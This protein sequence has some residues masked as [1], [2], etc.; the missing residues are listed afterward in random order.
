MRN[1]KFILA[2]VIVLIVSGAVHAQRGGRPTPAGG[3][4]APALTPMPTLARPNIS[5]T[6]QPTRTLPGNPSL[7]VIS[8]NAAAAV[9][10]FAVAHLGIT[11][12]ILY[13][14]D[15]SGATGTTNDTISVVIAQLPA[16]LQVF[17]ESTSN[18]SGAAYWGAWQTGA[19]VVALGDCTGNPNCTVSMDNLDLSITTSSGGVYGVYT[20]GAPT[21]SSDALRWITT[22]FP[23]L[24]GL[25]FAAVEAE[26][27]YAFQALT[28]TLGQTSTVK[29]VYAGT[30][31]AA[32][33]TLVYALVAVGDGYV[34]LALP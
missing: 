23:A 28:Y 30:I 15:F 21:S 10:N 33:Q 34:Q 18:F 16:E 2:L 19:G 1:V 6:P 4:G 27:G 3:R 12:D 25:P 17:V 9:T 20:A 11:L 32:G 5:L 14:G 31:S 29:A 22:T 26:Q 24:A 8:A 7:P 13:A